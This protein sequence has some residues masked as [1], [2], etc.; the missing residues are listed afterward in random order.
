MPPR[1]NRTH[2]SMSFS[3]YVWILVHFSTLDTCFS[4]IREFPLPV[5]IERNATT[6][7]LA[8]SARRLGFVIFNL[9]AIQEHSAAYAQRA[10]PSLVDQTSDCLWRDITNPGRFRL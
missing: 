2:I 1:H 9:T 8:R 5:F 3:I 6:G 4:T 7:S 10:K